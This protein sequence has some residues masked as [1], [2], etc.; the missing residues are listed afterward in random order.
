MLL[1]CVPIWL[2]VPPGGELEAMGPEPTCVE[3]G[4]AVL[5]ARRNQM[6][7]DGNRI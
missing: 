7:C 5:L 3:E 4:C 1:T 2:R 6:L